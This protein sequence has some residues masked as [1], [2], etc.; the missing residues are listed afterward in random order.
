[1]DTDEHHVGQC[2]GIFF[3]ARNG[4]TWFL[5]EWPEPERN[6]FIALATEFGPMFLL[7]E[8]GKLEYH[9]GVPAK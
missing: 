8:N 3:L 5:D 4:T 9:K 1:M 2:G 7:E 6:Q